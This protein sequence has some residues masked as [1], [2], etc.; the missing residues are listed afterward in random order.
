MS[1]EICPFNVLHG[2]CGTRCLEGVPWDQ[3]E[4]HLKKI[5]C[6]AWDRSSKPGYCKL[7]DP[8]V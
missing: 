4:P 5:P 7:I 8:E 3:Q 1:E 6:R 2:Q